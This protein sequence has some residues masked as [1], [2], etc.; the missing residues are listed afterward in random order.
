MMRSEEEFDSDLDMI[1][2]KPR[3]FQLKDFED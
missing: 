1:V 2:P 3:I